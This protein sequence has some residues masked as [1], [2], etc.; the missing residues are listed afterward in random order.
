[1]NATVEN[2]GAVAFGGV[3][4]VA[5]LVASVIVTGVSARTRFVGRGRRLAVVVPNHRGRPVPV[6][7]G[8]VLLALLVPVPWVDSHVVRSPLP[9]RWSAWLV[10]GM[11]VV[12]AAGYADDLQAERLRGVRTHFAHLRRGRVT[13]GIWKL[14]AA[15]GAALA[16]TLVADGS[17]ERVL[18]GTPVIAGMANLWNL[19]DVAPGRALK[20]G[21]LAGVVLSVARVSSLAATAAGASAGLLFADVRER[22]MLGDGG[23]NLLGFVLGIAL[24]QR[25]SIVGLA[26]AL[27]AIVALHLLAETVTLS[28]VIRAVLP[29]RWFDDLGRIP[30]AEPEG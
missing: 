3:V 25:L 16:W 8:L 19:L 1:V 20:F 27:T 10:A 22:G 14:V 13:T 28:R 29:L 6:V 15:V 23:A 30:L 5:S 17:V 2:T 11:L 26:V 9:W 7:L 4:A 12:F 21:V 24:Y 18:L